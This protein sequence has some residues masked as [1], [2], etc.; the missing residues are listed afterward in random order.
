MTSLLRVFWNICLL[1]AGPQHLPVSGFLSRFTLTCYF[2]VGIIASLNTL[3]LLAAMIPA[4]ADTLLLA[5]FAYLLLWI[6]S[7]TARYTQVLT[8][9]AGT[10][11]VL[12]LLGLPIVSWWQNLMAGINAGGGTEGN[13]GILLASWV[14]VWAWLFWNLVVIGQIF[15]NALSTIFIIGASV[16]LLYMYVSLNV[17]RV[18]YSLVSG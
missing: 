4:A 3:P 18:L 7:L 9:L 6:R 14:L 8:A 11:T 16:A 2:L 10:G 12:G 17:S 5:V 1:R 15:R 13:D